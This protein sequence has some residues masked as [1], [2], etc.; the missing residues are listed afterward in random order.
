ML[1]LGAVP[2]TGRA[3]EPACPRPAHWAAATGSTDPRGDLRVV[4]VQA[5]QDVSHVVTAQSYARWVSCL[6]ADFVAPHR[7]GTTLVVFNED[8]GLMTLA[9]GPQGALVRAQAQSAARAPAG[10][11]EPLSAAAASRPRNDGQ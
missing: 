9:T 10:D 11:R 2:A 4:G 6:T 1:L 7:R 5:L 3:V 8:I